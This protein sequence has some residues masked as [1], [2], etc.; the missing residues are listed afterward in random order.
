[1]TDQTQQTVFEFKYCHGCGHK[2]H[3]SARSCPNCGAQQNMN[4]ATIAT[5]SP[6]NWKHLY[7]GVQGRIG[8]QQW[9][10]SH[11]LLIVP[12]FF[13]GFLA[14]TLDKP[15]GPE[16]TPAK[17][18]FGVLIFVWFVAYI[19]SGIC[20]NAKRWHDRDYSGWMQLVG[21]IPLVG[22]WVLIE[23]GFLRG[24]DGPNRFGTDPL[25]R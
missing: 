25:Q 8:R 3:K 10:I 1:L 14:G 23:N 2:L 18:I 12:L 16:N 20:L 6:Q 17:A 7:F 21:I 19:W 24:T 5:A 11:L 15:E 22:I 13:F 9:W 4:L